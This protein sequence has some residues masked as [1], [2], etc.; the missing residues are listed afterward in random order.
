MK[1]DIWPEDYWGFLGMPAKS[2]EQT[3]TG[4]EAIAAERQRQ[5]EKEGWTPEH[6]DEHDDGSLAL[7]AAILATPHHL[8]RQDV[9][10]FDDGTKVVTFSDPWPPS[11]HDAWDKRGEA[12]RKRLIEIAGALLAAEYDRLTRA[13]QSN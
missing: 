10:E 13:G 7:V 12:D 11:W 4:I 3:M 9:E 6:D 8:F 1:D 5:I 2:K